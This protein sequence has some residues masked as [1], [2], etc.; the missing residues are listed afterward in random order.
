MA[1]L[2]LSTIVPSFL[3]RTGRMPGQRM[4]ANGP[5]CSCESC[6]DAWDRNHPP[7]SSR[8]VDRKN[9]RTNVG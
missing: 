1:P 2:R 8:R 9:L 7:G 4:L 3:R 6:I 5:G